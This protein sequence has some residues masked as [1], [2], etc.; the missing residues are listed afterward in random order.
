MASEAIQPD[1]I[2]PSTT[3]RLHILSMSFVIYF[4]FIIVC[5]LS[6]FIL[7]S[8]HCL[9]PPYLRSLGYLYKKN[10]PSEICIENVGIQMLSS[11][12]DVNQWT[13]L[14]VFLF[15]ALVREINTFSRQFEQ[16]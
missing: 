14:S 4:L 16:Q 12:H 1:T 10:R 9:A 3:Y 8:F 5:L 6:L 2:F 11:I 7:M 13:I 15:R